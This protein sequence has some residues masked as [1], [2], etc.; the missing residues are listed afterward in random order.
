MKFFTA[1]VRTSPY[2]IIWVSKVQK[3]GTPNR[4][5]SKKVLKSDYDSIYTTGFVNINSL[6]SFFG[7]Y[8]G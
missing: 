4:R 5:P 2:S 6:I 8:L 7:D 3:R 1:S